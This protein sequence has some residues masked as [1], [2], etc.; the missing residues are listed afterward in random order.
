MICT[1]P[2]SQS[3]GQAGT[4]CSPHWDSSRTPQP[5]SGEAREGFLSSSLPTGWPQ[6]LLVPGAVAPEGQ[7]LVLLVEICA[8]PANPFLQ[9]AEA[10]M[11][12]TSIPPRF[13]SPANLLR[14]SLPHHP[15]LRALRQRSGQHI[16]GFQ[17]PWW[18]R[19]VLMGS[20]WDFWIQ[21][22]AHPPFKMPEHWQTLVLNRGC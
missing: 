9:A 20:G 3:C 19:L 2:C 14:C 12:G 17:P 1:N 18:P 16:E 13:L 15:S 21:S 10:P 11:D 6:H 8:A 5:G 7:E 22:G 4:T